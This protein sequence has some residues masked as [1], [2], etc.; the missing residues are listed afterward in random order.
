MPADSSTNVAKGSIGEVV[1]LTK[2]ERSWPHI[3]ALIEAGGHVTIGKIEPF[4]GVAVAAGGRKVF[5]TLV[6]RER[7]SAAALMQRLET[8]LDER[9]CRGVVTN[10]IEGGEFVLVGPS[11]R[12]KGRG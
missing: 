7:E 12:G 5:A 6:R 1:V 9:A 4:E 11:A 3:T 10:E 2:S 8:A